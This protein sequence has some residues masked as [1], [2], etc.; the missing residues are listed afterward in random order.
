MCVLLQA[1]VYVWNQSR[2]VCVCVCVCVCVRRSVCSVGEDGHRWCESCVCVCVCVC[3]WSLLWVLLLKR[4]TG[5][6]TVGPFVCMRRLVSMSVCI[7]MCVLLCV[8]AYQ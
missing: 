8:Y 5:V 1:T 6:V 2:P 7:C 3:V 4:L